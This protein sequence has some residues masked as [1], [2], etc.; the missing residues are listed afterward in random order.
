MKG[1]VIKSTGSWC[2][3]RDEDEN[4]IECR[5]KGKFRIDDIKSTNP[6][7][8]GDKVF[9]EVEK[10]GTGIIDDIVTRKNYIIRKATKLSKQTHII[11]SNI[12]Q[13]LLIVSLV[14]PETMTGFID[15]F[16]VTAEAYS[17]PTVIVFNKIDLYDAKNLEKLKSLKAV[18]E[19]IGYKCIEISAE[20]EIKL[21]LLKQIM[22]GKTSLLA[23]NS[24]VGK[25]TL[26]NKLEPGLNLKIAGVSSA[27][28]L[29]IHTTTFAEMFELSFGAFI[30]DT[31]GL[32][33]FGIVDFRKEELFHFFPE[34]FRIKDECKFGNCTHIN[35]PGCAVKKAVE[36]GEIARHR[37]INYLDIYNGDEM[38]VEY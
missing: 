30:I 33:S 1:I 27:H 9:F 28:H 37:Y 34:M 3:V 13:A 36:K 7:A 26:I 18:Y 23:G 20:K 32:K 35:E 16:L 6:V 29:G 19:K 15:R 21:D 14:F 8:V 38:K 10:D 31:P 22:M 12:D 25:S 4:K 17:I 11:A 5:I 24:G 2:T